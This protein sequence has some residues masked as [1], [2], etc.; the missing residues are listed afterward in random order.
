VY[1]GHRRGE[2]GLSLTEAL[3]AL[4]LLCVF[5]VPAMGM[6]RQ[7]A[8]NYS[9]AYADYQTDLAL[10][11]ILA[12]VKNSSETRD[13]FD[14]TLNFSEYPENGRYE[15]EVIIE[16]LQSGRANVIRYPAGGSLNIQTARLSQNGKFKGLITAAAKDIRTGLIKIKALPF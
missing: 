4:G 10:A 15:Y 13:I 16:D 11:N 7:S 2:S 5:I 6:L 8:G 9:R 14:I 3:V 1:N 12:Q